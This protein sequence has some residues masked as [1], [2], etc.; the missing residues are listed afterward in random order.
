MAE[1]STT[2]SR[3]AGRAARLRARAA[4]LRADLGATPLRRNLALLFGALIVA[5]IAWRVIA[6]IGHADFTGNDQRFYSTIAKNLANDF[7]Y[8]V[9]GSINVLHWAP[10]APTAFAIFYKIFGAGGSGYRGMYIAQLVFSLAALWAVYWFA[11]RFTRDRL[12]A[13]GAVAVLAIST[14]Q[15][16]TE[17]DL[18]TEPLGALL[19]LLAAGTLGFALIDER[20]RRHVVRWSLVSGT[21]LGL[22]IMT[23]PDFLLQPFAWALVVLIVWRAPWRARLEVVGAIAVTVFVVMFPYC[24][25]ASNKANQL[26]TPTTSGATTY[27]VGT[28]LPGGGTTN[29]AKRH[30]RQEIYQRVPTVRDERN[31]GADS[32]ILMLRR[33]YPQSWTRDEA[34]RQ[35]LKNNLRRYAWGD[36]VDF[37]LMMAE[38]PWLMWR[39][40]Y[41]GHAHERSWLGNALHVPTLIAAIVVLG[42]LL[43]LRRRDLRVALIGTTLVVGTAVASIGPAIPRA[44]ARYA[45]LVILGAALVVAALLERRRERGASP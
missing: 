22:A 37:W 7:K 15:V 2:A 39:L 16:R 3:P 17:T 24:F 31:P 4:E 30:L 6:S 45:P 18:I 23:R 14:G 19:L 40:P 38:K 44:N 21:L 5:G 28:Y 33:R 9:T 10:G 1:T 29:G 11:L 43:W 12:I 8:N 13:L 35:E 34:I 25:W 42:G 26:V 32:M 27:W 36:P 20:G 41:K